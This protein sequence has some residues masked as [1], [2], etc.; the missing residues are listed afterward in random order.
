[1]K[2]N[3][4]IIILIIGISSCEFFNEKKSLPQELPIDELTE[5]Q[6]DSVAKAPYLLKSKIELINEI[7]LDGTLE[8][9]FVGAYGKYSD[10][11]ARFKAFMDKTNKEELLNLLSHENPTVVCYTI[12]GL[13]EKEFKKWDTVIKKITQNTNCTMTLQGC[14]GDIR[15]VR[16]FFA[17]EIGLIKDT[18]Q[19]DCIDFEFKVE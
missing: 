8:E 14:I 1:M 17:T 12:L 5:E 13:K 9:K 2:L 4:Y 3:L 11:Y 7:A 19:N 18:F 6:Y 15:S 16:K 10:Q